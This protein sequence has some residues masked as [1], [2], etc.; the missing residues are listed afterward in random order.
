MH[1][2]KF[3]EYLEKLESTPSRLEM[4]SQLSTIFKELAPDEVAKASYLLEGRLMPQYLSLEFQ[5]SVKMVVRALARTEWQLPGSENTAATDTLFGEV[6]WLARESFVTSMYKRLGDVGAA[7]QELAQLQQKNRTIGVRTLAQT[8]DSA[9]VENVA[10]TEKDHIF[11]VGSELTITQV[12]SALFEIAGEGGSGSQERKVQLVVALL[13]QLDPISAKY[14]CRIIVGTMRLGF[15]TMTLLDALSWAMTGT[16]GESGLLEEAYQ[17]KADI[18][19]LAES[20]LTHTDE[21]KRQA[22]LSN[23]TIE[24]GVPIVPQLCQVLASPE[25]VIEKMEGIYVEAKYDGLRVQIHLSK[26]GLPNPLAGGGELLHIKAFTRNLEDSTH[27]FPELSKL[28]ELVD[29]QEAIFDGEAIGYDPATGKLLPFQETITR[30]R[31]HDIAKTALNVPLKFF[32]FDIL[33]IDG[34]SLL[35]TELRERKKLLEKTLQETEQFVRTNFLST[36]DP[37]ELQSF[38]EKQLAAGLE[39]VVIKQVES[40]YQSG[41]KGWYWVK[42]KQAA[43]AHAKLQ[44]TIDCVVLGYYLGRGKRTGFGLGAF[45]VGVLT[46]ENTVVTIAKVGTGM[47]DEQIKDLKRR[48]DALEVKTQPASY[49]VTKGLIPDVWITPQIVV[50]I[51]ADEVTRSPLHTAGVALRFPRLIKLRSDK[52]WGDATTL[53][54][55]QQI[56]QL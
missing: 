43:G 15:S 27:M 25:E 49:S 46:S 53:A 51:A 6:N 48:A 9:E 31:K 4:T 13:N 8:A 37:K 11:S 20:Y 7:A 42:M 56:A 54:Q 41:R 26:K 5:M 47:S 30:K 33:S 38:H 55:L 2:S 23:Y 19:K 50:E 45:L 52:A 35:Q 22:A 3:S 21:A 16:K 40:P 12:Y 18:G 36:S 14:V 1:F 29:A 44:D 17:K 10:D 32:I 34:K 28:L 24:V 39:G